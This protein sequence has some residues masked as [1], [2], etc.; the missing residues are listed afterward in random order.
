MRVTG[1]VRTIDGTNQVYNDGKIVI[2]GV[3]CPEIKDQKRDEETEFIFSM[4]TQRKEN[5]EG[6]STSSLSLRANTGPVR[7]GTI[8]VYKKIPLVS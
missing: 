4:A 3:L 2:N 6:P 8:S 7:Q 5:T 1:K